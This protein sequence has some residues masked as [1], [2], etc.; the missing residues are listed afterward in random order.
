MTNNHKL[1][2]QITNEIISRLQQ[3]EIPWH[4]PWAC[5]SA[6]VSHATGNPY[7]LLNCLLLEQ[8]G[9]YVTYLQAQA[10]GGH[11]RKGAR[12]KHIYFWKPFTRKEIVRDMYGNEIIKEKIIPMLRTYCVFHIDDCE[13]IEAKY[14][15][16]KTSFDN[17]PEERAEQVANE[18]INREGLIFQNYDVDEAYFSPSRDLVQV[19]PLSSH[20]SSANYYSTLFHELTHSSGIPKR[21]NRFEISDRDPSE[22]AKEELVAELGAAMMLAELG[23]ENN[24]VLTNSAA[25]IQSWIKRLRDDPQMIV[26]A[27]SKAE[28]AV[29][30]I[31]GEKI[32]TAA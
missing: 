24:K 28:K 30:F 5:S 3:G 21:L 1:Y 17:K 25:Y 9:E 32:D 16:D 19:P 15:A 4:K 6:F 7:S 27:S 2:E 31:L 8:P 14:T 22:Y 11:V 10:E 29:K 13:G 20:K 12:S 18:Y 26:A 23:I